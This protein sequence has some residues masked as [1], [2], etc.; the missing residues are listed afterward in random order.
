[1]KESKAINSSL[2]VLGK[3]IGALNAKHPRIPYCDRKLTGGPEQDRVHP[4]VAV[5]DVGEVLV[6][7]VVGPC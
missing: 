7:G 1:M 6:H 3:V 2:M 5:A 4:A